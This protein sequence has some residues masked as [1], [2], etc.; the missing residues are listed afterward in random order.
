MA[1]RIHLLTA[2]CVA[3]S[4]FLF[5][6][7]VSADTTVHE[8]TTTVTTPAH[9]G[10]MA[11]P[12][13]IQAKELNSEKAIEKSFKNVTEYAV[14]KTGFDNIVSYLADQDKDRIKKSTNKSLNDL[15]GN[16]NASLR[17]AVD[18]LTANWNTKYGKKF[19]IDYK[20][21][22]TPDFLHIMTGEV[23]DPTLLIGKWPV[24]NLSMDQGGKVT[25]GDAN[26]AKNK[27]YGGDV[28]LEKGRDVAIAHLDA[29]HGMPGV[30]A[31]MIHEVASGWHFDIPNNIDAGMLYNNLVTNLNHCNNM[32][33][34]WPADVNDGYRAVTH[35]VIAALYNVN[36]DNLPK[37]ATAE[38]R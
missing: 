1:M 4:A 19:D 8:K 34:K 7:P 11:L 35:A 21:V 31:S 22:Y 2:A 6:V 30:T 25:A 9:E 26:I 27:M 29:S 12:S 33:D 28:N 17:D 15:D 3:T 5:A 38:E 18:K 13:G 37:N 20:S 16:K 14:D 32:K 24:S 23:T 10:A 36:L